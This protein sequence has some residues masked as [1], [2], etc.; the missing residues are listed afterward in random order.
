MW[1]GD[2]DVWV[3]DDVWV[4]MMW[5][6]EIAILGARGCYDV[7][8]YLCACTCM[9][10]CACIHACMRLWVCVCV[11]M[12]INTRVRVQD[13]LLFEYVRIR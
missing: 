7:C 2:D 6:V 4:M 3:G 9:S 12:H 8:V 1:G 13:I 10:V 11:H 5:V